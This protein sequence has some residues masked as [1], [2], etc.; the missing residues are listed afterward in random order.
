MNS[1]AMTI[2]VIDAVLAVVFAV[3]GVL[4]ITRRLP[5]NRVVGI[6]TA[7]T[8]RSDATFAAA[9]ATAGPGLVAGSVVLTL[10]AMLGL[11]LS[12]AAATGF[13]AIG[14]LAGL[15]LLG[16]ASS[17]GLRAAAAVPDWDDDAPSC[18]TAGGCGSCSF[19]DACT[20]DR[21]TNT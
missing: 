2:A 18:G 21:T 9:H 20:P 7:A 15:V 19:A 1:V 13:A 3:V 11:G 12:G 4:G 16:S 14:L 10:G 17:F 5:R 8:L 6:R